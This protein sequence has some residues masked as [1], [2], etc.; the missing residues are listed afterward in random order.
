MEQNIKN[1]IKAIKKTNIE[2]MRDIKAVKNYALNN[3]MYDLIV[4]IN[5]NINEYFNYI[6]D[7]QE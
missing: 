3:K 4:F 6:K 5:E 1:E 2:D 7:L